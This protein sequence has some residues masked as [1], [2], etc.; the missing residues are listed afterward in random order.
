M[1]YSRSFSF[2]LFK[3]P[4]SEYRGTPFWAWNCALNGDEL[5]RQIE[6][7]KEMGLG[8]FHMHSRTGTVT[9]YLSD[10]FMDLVK[11]CRDKAREENMLCWLYDEDRW[12]SGAAGGMVTKNPAYRARHLLVTPWAYGEEP[13]GE[14]GKNE[15]A[16]GARTGKGTLLARYE[17][18]LEKGLLAGYK[19]LKMREEGK[20]VWYAYEEIADPSP[21]FNNQTYLDTLNPRAVEEFVKVTHEAY[22]KAVGQDFG[23]VI[24]AIFTDE[25]QFTHKT[26]LGFAHEKKDIF[27][28]YTSDL[29][30]S[31]NRAYGVSLLDCLPEIVWNLSDDRFPENRYRYHDHVAERFAAAFADTVG[32]WCR[33]NGIML[34]GHMMEEPTLA[35]QSNA[36]GDCMRSYRGFQLPG[37]DML[38]DRREYTTAKQAQSAARQYGAPGVLSELYGVTNWDFD[39]RGHKLQGDWQAALGV[40]V[41]VHHLTWVSMGGESKRDY[42]ASMGYQSPWFKEYP[43]VE[44][45]FARVNTAMAAGKARVRIGVIHPVESYWI[46]MGP[47]EQTGAVRRE[48]EENFENTVDWLLHEHL[49]FDFISESLLPEQMDLGGTGLPGVGKMTYEALLVP[50]CRILRKS[51]LSFIEAFAK[52]GGAVVF[53]G[54]IPREAEEAVKRSSRIPHSRPAL[55]R[56]LEPFREVSLKDPRGMESN[57]H[58]YQLREEGERAYLFIAPSRLPAN[59]DLPGPEEI[60]ISIRGTW[61]VTLLD[62]MTGDPSPLSTACGDG[63]TGLVRTFDH[64]DSLL[65]LL[66]KTQAPDFPAPSASPQYEKREIPLP[67]RWQGK[68]EEPNVLLLDMCRWSL[69]DGESTGPEEIL[70]VDDA[71]REELGWASRS[72]RVCQPWAAPEFGGEPARVTLEYAIE[73]DFECPGVSLALEEPEETAVSL[74]GREI[75]NNLTGWYV[76]KSIKTLSLGTIPKG[77][78]VLTLKRPL[79]PSSNLEGIFLLGEFDVSLEG[80]KAVL[81]PPRR[82]FNF[83]SLSDQDMPFYGGNADYV[84]ELNLEPGD[85]V[86]QAEFFRAPLLKLTVGDKEMP[87]AFSP[88]EAEFSLKEKGPVKLTL[89]S[90]GSRINTFG[91]LHNCD[92]TYSWWGPPSWRTKDSSW[93]YEYQIRETGLLKA[94]RLFLKKPL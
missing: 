39:F 59:G 77:K 64:H 30:E 90:F 26:N 46:N 67:R 81:M 38:C 27:L 63:W 66:E 34:T 37:I 33:D 84:T 54:H 94:P 45:H 44:D 7:F 15:S 18:T 4:T 91:Q 50:D 35:S 80:M 93:A 11:L 70:R 72:T 53:S 16:R 25:P 55:A 13:R 3:N 6:I 89:T 10:E 69:Q 78:S 51:T 1:L 42:P 47:L 21:W 79:T 49:D 19:R 9:P 29:D 22:K 65:L 82:E 83:T 58:I 56:A 71:I 86:F 14:D 41:R 62:T 43:L 17:V 20:N 76:D 87:I 68:R 31:F 88:Y 85:Y 28:P 75:G 5:V 40:T 57:R 8:G 73:S 23:G 2:P 60:T 24:P 36:L 61:K 32:R 92:R 12:P 52:R 48:L 74:N